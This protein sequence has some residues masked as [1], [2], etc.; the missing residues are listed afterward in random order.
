MFLFVSKGGQPS[1]KNFHI[2]PVF[3]FA[4]PTLYLL[5]FCIVQCSTCF[6]LYLCYV[7][8]F[9][10]FFV[11]STAAHA[12]CTAGSVSCRMTNDPA[13]SHIFSAIIQ[14]GVFV[15]FSFKDDFLLFLYPILSASFWIFSLIGKKTL[16]KP[17][18]KSTK[19]IHD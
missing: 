8:I 9:V 6:Y 5:Y 13:V 12:R 11:F 10:V 19:H 4:F 15:V 16:Y 3:A 18:N 2:I 7:F 17:K 14:G 1:Q